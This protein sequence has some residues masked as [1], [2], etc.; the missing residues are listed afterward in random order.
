MKIINEL[1]RQYFISPNIKDEDV[2]QEVA[3][4]E[5][6]LRSVVDADQ[7]ID[8]QE[9]FQEQ[10]SQEQEE[11]HLPIVAHMLT[12][13]NWV[14]F[15]IACAGVLMTLY[16]GEFLAF[17]VLAPIAISTIITAN[18]EYTPDIKIFHHIFGAFFILLAI[19]MV[20]GTM[21]YGNSAVAGATFLLLQLV[22]VLIFT[23]GIPLLVDRKG[24][25]SKYLVQYTKSA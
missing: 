16:T 3:K 25:K 20:L 6:V 7:F 14:G 24:F 19:F 15:T 8:D 13:L 1:R 4:I 23:T 11:G 21:D 22:C 2:I 17:G 12:F 10:D 18:M 5:E 9:I